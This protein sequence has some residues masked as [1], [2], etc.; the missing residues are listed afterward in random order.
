MARIVPDLTNYVRVEPQPKPAPIFIPQTKSP[1]QRCI[2]AFPL[3][4]PGDIL[5]Q[6]ETPG[7]PQVRF[8]KP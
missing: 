8:P 4:Q 5:R 1:Y 2:L 7:V 3:S 6:W